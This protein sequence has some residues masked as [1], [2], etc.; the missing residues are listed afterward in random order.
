ML[1]FLLV[2]L[3]QISFS[4]ESYLITLKNEKIYGNI[5]FTRN[6]FYDEIQIKNDDGRRTYKAYQIESANVDGDLYEPITYNNRKVIGKV[7][8]KGKLNRYLVMSE[9]SN[10]FNTEILFKDSE[11]S[12][13]VSNLGFRKRLIDFLKDCPSLSQKIENKEIPVSNLERITKE[14]N[15][16]CGRENTRPLIM[17]SKTQEE[18]NLVD[19]AQLILDINNKEKPVKKYQII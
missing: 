18:T 19:F 10:G 6:N 15:Q 12:L 8:T 4:Q 2:V 13:L 11:K 17:A 7:I 14:Y 16:N 9:G 5:G 1:A 3:S